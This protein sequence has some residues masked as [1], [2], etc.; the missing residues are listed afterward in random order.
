MLNVIVITSATKLILGNQR[1]GI[2]QDKSR[3]LLEDKLF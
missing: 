2:Y 3:H 1:E